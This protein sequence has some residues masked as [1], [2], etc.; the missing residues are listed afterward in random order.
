[1]GETSPTSEKGDGLLAK[2]V[3]STSQAQPGGVYQGFEINEIQGMD[4]HKSGSARTMTV[5]QYTYLRLFKGVTSFSGTQTYEVTGDLAESWEFTDGGQQLTLKLRPGVTWDRRAPTNGRPVDAQDVTFSADRF[6]ASSSYASNYFNAKSKAAPITALETPDDRTVVLKLAFPYV[7]LLATFSRALNMWIIP[8]EAEG[9][10]NPLTDVRGAG[11]WLLDEYTPSVGLTFKRNP[12]YYVKDRPFLDGWSSPIVPEYAARI[13]QFRAGNIWGGVARQEDVLG[14]K[15]DLPQLNLIQGNY[16][17]DTPL[18]YFGYQGPFKDVRLRQAVA[19]VIDRD[20]LAETLSDSKRFED[21][22]LPKAVRLNTHIGAGWD[23]WLDPAGTEF[24]PNAKYYRHDLAEAK[25]LMQAAGVNGKLKTRFYYPSDGYGATYQATVP[26]LAEMM[27][28]SGLFETE[29]TPLNYQNEY[30]PK[31]H[32]GG[33]R[34]GGWDGVALTPAA[35]GDEAGH[36]LQ[37]QYHSAGAASRQ[38]PGED[39]KLDQMIEAQL[40]ETDPKKRASMIHEIQRSMP[41]T[42]IAV[43]VF[44]QAAGFGLYWPWAGNVSAVRGTKVPPAEA[45]PYL[46][47][48]KVAHERAKPR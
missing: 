34:I 1:T 39:P 29:L 37:V 14:L 2:P 4:P 48:D 16:G 45:H 5:A 25:K 23:E 33:E 11:P 43:P 38:P 32:F 9:G 3:D 6:L 21:A 44:Y 20:L 47:Y 42:M 8:R 19:Q 13:A 40:R 28:E 18:I 22:G 36:Q 10:F 15:R 12:D 30:I 24:G 35:Q 7:P 31:I 17:V 26:I 41:E 46:W 27:N